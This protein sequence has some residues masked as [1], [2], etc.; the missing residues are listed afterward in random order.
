MVCGSIMP[1]AISLNYARYMM[2]ETKHLIS[3]TV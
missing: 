3:E 2:G 1:E